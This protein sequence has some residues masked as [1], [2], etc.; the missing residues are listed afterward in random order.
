MV[1]LEYMHVWV[2]VLGMERNMYNYVHA[3]TCPM[4]KCLLF[5]KF[6]FF[7]IFIFS[8]CAWKYILLCLWEQVTMG[9]VTII[10]Y[11][12]QKEG[13]CCQVASPFVSSEVPNC[14][15]CL[16]YA[17]SSVHVPALYVC[18]GDAWYAQQRSCV[19]SALSFS[20][21]WAGGLIEV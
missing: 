21:R 15:P 1:M 7:H 4:V 5:S 16:W 19:V 20:G 18:M 3:H 2:T 13:I 11:V 6:V 8:R 9:F 17:S 12:V 14:R 10:F